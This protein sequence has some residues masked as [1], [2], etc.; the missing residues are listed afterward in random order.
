[1]A[2]IKLNESDLKNIIFRSIKKHIN[3]GGHLYGI[4]SDDNI[5]TNSK[6]T[7]RNVPGTTYI[8]HGEWSD[9]EVI[10]KGKELNANDIEDYLWSDFKD[11]TGSDDESMFDEW[12]ENQGIDYLKS[13]LDDMVS[14]ME[15]R[16]RR[17]IKLTESTLNT[18]IKNSLQ[19]I[20]KEGFEINGGPNSFY[21][22]GK[23]YIYEVFYNFN[24]NEIEQDAYGSYNDVDYD[25]PQ[26]TFSIIKHN[27]DIPSNSSYYDR[28][29]NGKGEIPVF[30]ICVGNE[31]EELEAINN[32]FYISNM[33]ADYS[34]E[35]TKALH[36]YGY[37]YAK[38]IT[39]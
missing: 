36:E 1:M 20:L 24:T 3:E 28:F 6:E 16:R 2:T 15:N 11:E 26:E 30:A 23:Y 13:V 17:T 29:D 35:I 4:D 14:F 7:Y 32:K 21:K 39:L 19:K 5:F 34:E 22:E 27:A 33:F 18:L 9:P 38:V 12:V 8:Y 37:D 10:Y 25:T 31:Y